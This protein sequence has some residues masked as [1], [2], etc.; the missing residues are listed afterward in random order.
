[1]LNLCTSHCI[2]ALSV[3]QIVISLV[4]LVYFNQKLVSPSNNAYA[5]RAYIEALLNY[6]SSAKTSF[7][8]LLMGRG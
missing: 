8:L 7:N 6:A 1:M 4:H 3:S 2:G 5:Y